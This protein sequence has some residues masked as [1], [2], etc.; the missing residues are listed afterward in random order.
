[1][2]SLF[3]NWKSHKNL[4]TTRA[5]VNTFLDA[6]DIS[7]PQAVIESRI[8][9]VLFPPLPL[10]YPLKQLVSDSEIT[11][12]AQDI[13]ALPEG[14]HTG[15]VAS[16]SLAGI[17]THVILGHVETRQSGD[18]QEIVQAKFERALST[19]LAPLVCVTSP[20]QVIAES[21]YIVYEPAASVG[22]GKVAGIDDI[23]NFKSSCHLQST[24]KFIYG[25][26]VSP[27]NVTDLM[28]DG[29]IDGVLV[30]TDSLD[31]LVFAQLVNNIL[32]HA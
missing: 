17:A 4:I 28:K 3:A 23:A 12:G 6:L 31:P 22:T 27:E 16:E 8:E 20:E 26:S 1:M 11:V 24:Q 7:F 30:G 15:Q 18:T 5:W 25:G 19:N 21:P 13:S 9:L 29:V 10:I 2:F 32:S 14:K